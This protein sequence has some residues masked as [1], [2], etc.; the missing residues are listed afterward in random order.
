MSP[1]T[2]SPQGRLKGVRQ[3]G[4]T[5]SSILIHVIFGTKDRRPLIGDFRQR[6]YEYLVGVANMIPCCGEQQSTWADLARKRFLT[7]SV[8]K[9]R[10]RDGWHALLAKRVARICPEHGLQ[11]SRATLSFGCFLQ[12]KIVSKRLIQRTGSWGVSLCPTT[13]GGCRKCL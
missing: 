6:L 4:H 13:S 3:M 7:W 10:F 12:S 9:I 5:F 8:E 2:G 11:A 1:R